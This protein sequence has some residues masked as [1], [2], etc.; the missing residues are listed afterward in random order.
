MQEV[1]LHYLIYVAR[2]V[3]KLESVKKN[4]FIKKFGHSLMELAFLT[5]KENKEKV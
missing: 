2:V 5:T 1:A 4:S 3:K